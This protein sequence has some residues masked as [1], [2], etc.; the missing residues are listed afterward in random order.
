MHYTESTQRLCVCLTPLHVLI[1]ARLSER[2]GMRFDVG[3]Y[4]AYQHDEKQNHYFHRMSAFCTRT[5]WITPPKEEY[6][7]GFAKYFA[8]YKR[9][10]QHLRKFLELGR[11]S[12]ALTS[13]SIN[14]Y[15]W[16]ILEA[17]KPAR[18]ETYDDGLLNIASTPAQH[19]QPTPWREKLFLRLCGIALNKDMLIKKSAQHYTIYRG[20]NLF[21]NTQQIDLCPPP[22]GQAKYLDQPAEAVEHIFLCPAPEAPAH[23]WR[24]VEQ[25]LEDHPSIA[26]LPH[27]RGMKPIH[28]AS[29]PLNTQLI[30]EDHVLNQLSKKR[31]RF[32]LIGTESSALINLAS[33]PGVETWSVLPNIPEHA[34][35]RALMA[36]HGVRLLHQS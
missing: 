33:I 23:V 35:S 31:M 12:Y 15:L 27:P 16:C 6:P 1:A 30:I 25:Y 36:Q 13:C 14:H 29:R 20:T 32:K 7:R 4:L 19:Y 28:I 2:T 11:F 18:L 10:K 17:C 26:H 24:M 34:E 9:R 5:Q 22:I 3:V 8:L 21:S